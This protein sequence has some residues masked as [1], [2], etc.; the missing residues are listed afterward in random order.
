MPHVEEGIQ[1]EEDIHHL[2]YIWWY[3]ANSERT[4]TKLPQDPY[5]VMRY[6][7]RGWTKRVPQDAWYKDRKGI[8]LINPTKEDFLEE[9]KE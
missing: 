3:K 7:E 4:A 8:H 5:H 9:D 2:D 6:T 1:V